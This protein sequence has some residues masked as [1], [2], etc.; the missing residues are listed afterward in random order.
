MQNTI[1]RY[2]ALHGSYNI[3]Q[4]AYCEGGECFAVIKQEDVRASSHLITYLDSLLSQNE[5]TLQDLDFF[6]VDYGPGAFTSLRVTI[7]AVNGLG[8]AAR[9]RLIPV[10]GLDALL[11]QMLTVKSHES[12]VFVALLNAYN[13][14]VYYKISAPG[15]VLKQASLQEYGYSS[16]D[17]L[18]QM[19]HQEFDQDVTILCAGNGANMH[20][21]TLKTQFPLLQIQSDLLVPSI[22]YIAQLG[23][24][25]WMLGNPGVTRITPLYLKTQLFAV[26]QK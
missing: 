13:N 25:Q 23:F 6:V 18:I 2:I 20:A 21:S 19:L 7:A 8:F 4:L 5:V 17:S 9:T 1:P 26:T 16:I 12:Q 22:E 24:E 3:L 10:S 11:M 15:F 14:E